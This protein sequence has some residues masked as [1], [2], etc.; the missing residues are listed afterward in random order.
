[1]AV[2]KWTRLLGHMVH[3]Y[4]NTKYFPLITTSFHIKVDFFPVFCPS[5]LAFCF[6]LTCCYVY[7]CLSVFLPLCVF[8]LSSLVAASWTVCP[9]SAAVFNYILCL[10]LCLSPVY[11]K[12]DLRAPRQNTDLSK[13]WTWA[14]LGRKNVVINYLLFLFSPL[15]CSKAYFIKNVL[16]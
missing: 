7:S 10:T 6:C 13:A 14:D 11:N 16:F 1:M 15:V 12:W 8:F 5:F 2:L 9:C 3:I 4:Y